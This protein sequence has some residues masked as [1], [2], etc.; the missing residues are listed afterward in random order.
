MKT[1]YKHFLILCLLI[2]GCASPSVNYTKYQ[3]Q[4]DMKQQ[5]LQEDAKDFIA[6]A[7]SILNKTDLKRSEIKRAI[8]II[9]KSQTLL[10]AKV[11]DGAEYKE[12]STESQDKAISKVFNED[13][14][15][16]SD[17]EVLEEKDKELVSKIV[18]DNI[19]AETIKDY[20]RKKTI[21]LYAILGIILSSLGALFYF[22]PAKFLGIGARIVG[23]FVK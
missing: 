20:E 15:E 17:I 4:I 19:K 6:T 7:K 12:L 23:F 1:L 5:K 22:F 13:K 18:T 2:S 16:L 8:S 9:E 11:D 3:K 14:K 21:K 10:G